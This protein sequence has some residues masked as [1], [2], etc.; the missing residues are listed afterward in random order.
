MSIDELLATGEKAFAEGGLT[1][2]RQCFENILHKEPNH[3]EALNNLAAVDAEHGDYDEAANNLLKALA[4]APEDCLTRENL[5]VIY[6][7]QHKYNQAVC[8]YH[9][10]LE[11][12]KNNGD[13]YANLSLCLL[14]MG[15]VEE[16]Q[17]ALNKAK[18]LDAD[19]RLVDL[20][21]ERLASISKQL[22]SAAIRK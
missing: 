6:Q 13:L 12:E 20:I 15:D 9:K 11:Q 3:V 4:L 14:E 8:F 10:V 18:S 17:S 19:A 21:S 1:T 22:R 16:A 2:A 7:K 5:A